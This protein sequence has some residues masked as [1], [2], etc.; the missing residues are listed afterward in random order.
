MKYINKKARTR[1]NDDDN[2]HNN[3]HPGSPP[4]ISQTLTRE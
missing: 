4:T 3:H 1:D 2:D